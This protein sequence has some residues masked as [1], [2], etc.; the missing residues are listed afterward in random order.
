M[1]Y[2]CVELDCVLGL[3]IGCVSDLDSPVRIPPVCME[4]ATNRVVYVTEPCVT[5]S[6]V[7]CQVFGRT[8]AGWQR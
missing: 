8:K 7:F 3:C 6:G 4:S 2:L 1:P 5:T